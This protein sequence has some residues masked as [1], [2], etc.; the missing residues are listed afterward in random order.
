MSSSILPYASL[1]RP[2]LA[3]FARNSIL[4]DSNQDYLQAATS[5]ISMASRR[6]SYYDS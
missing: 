2:H 6:C 5:I 4:R 3:K 1:F